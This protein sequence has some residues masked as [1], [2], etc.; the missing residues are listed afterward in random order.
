MS[1]GTYDREDAGEA[2]KCGGCGKTMKGTDVHV[3]GETVS[4]KCYR[5]FTCRSGCNRVGF[6][7][8]DCWQECRRKREKKT[9]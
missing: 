1:S 5:A 7:E 6:E 3:T 4:F 9:R 2:V 8:L